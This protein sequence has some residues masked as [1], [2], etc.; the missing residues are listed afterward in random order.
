MPLPPEPTAH[1]PPCRPAGK[2]AAPESEGDW[3][4]WFSLCTSARS[5]SLRS[6]S[7][8]DCR[9][10]ARPTSLKDREQAR[11]SN[12]PMS[13]TSCVTKS[14]QASTTSRSCHSL[15]SET[16]W[17]TREG[18]SSNTSFGSASK[19]MMRRS[20]SMPTLLAPRR[21]TSRRPCG[22]SGSPASNVRAKYPLLQASTS[23]CAG[24]STPSA[25]SVT[26]ASVSDLRS[27]HRLW[28]KGSKRGPRAT[29][30]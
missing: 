10:I 27:Q 22:H 19:Y 7:W 17:T 29:S 26:S 11:F 6:R 16:M 12:K 18:S 23:R 20:C 28:T 30:R 5:R 14:R 25:F 3:Q 8:H 1:L 9:T 4:L 13:S 24:N 2:P 21:S 15:A